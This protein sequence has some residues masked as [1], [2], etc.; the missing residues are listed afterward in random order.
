ML[1]C[2]DKHIQC[3]LLVTEPKAQHICCI[4]QLDQYNKICFLFFKKSWYHYWFFYFIFDKLWPDAMQYGLCWVKSGTKWKNLYL[5]FFGQ[6]T[7]INIVMVIR[8]QYLLQHQYSCNNGKAF[9]DIGGSSEFNM[10]YAY[11]YQNS[12]HYNMLPIQT[13]LLAHHQWGSWSGFVS[14]I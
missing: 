8:N 10:K 13:T 6:K 2:N 1:R 11:L 5:C 7:V 12:M 3:I 14:T 4:D 9:I